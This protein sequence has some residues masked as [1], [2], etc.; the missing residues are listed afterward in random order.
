MKCKKTKKQIEA[1]VRELFPELDESFTYGKVR[2]DIS[3]DKKRVVLEL[4]TMYS[5]LEL[6]FS[7]LKKL[8]EFLSCNEISD[9]RTSTS[10]CDT[11]DYGSSYNI[12]LTCWDFGKEM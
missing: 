2:V 1:K 7:H 5:F 4:S 11:C 6:Q 9:S 10:G 12:T 3:K 8:S